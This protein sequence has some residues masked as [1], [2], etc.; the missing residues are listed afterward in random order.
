[1]QNLRPES[2]AWGRWLGLLAVVGMFVGGA[3]PFLPQQCL[4]LDEATQMTGLRLGPTGVA[5]WLAGGEPH[6]TGQFRDRM[7]PLSYWLGWVWAR[8]FGFDEASLRWFGVTCVAVAAALVYEA[9]RLALGTASAWVAGLLFAL[10]PAVIVLSVEIRAYPLFVLWSAVAFYGLV[11]LHATSPDERRATFAAL[12]LALSAAVST[13]FFGAVLGGSML[14]TLLI[15]AYR[16]AGRLRLIVGVGGVFAVTTASLLPFIIASFAYSKHGITPGVGYGPRLG[17]VKNM[18]VRL[19][20]HG[21]LS[22]HRP[23]A[24]VA[25]AAAVVLIVLAIGA[26]RSSR[27]PVVA[28]ALTLGI[29]LLVVTAAKL[30]LNT[31]D[32]A[33]SNYNVWMRPGFCILL[34][35]GIASQSRAVRRVAALAFGLLLVAQMSGAYQL[36]VHGNYFAHGPHRTIAELIHSLNTRD[37][38]VVHDDPSHRFEFVYCPI[39]Y[40]LGPGL[41]HY[42][43]VHAPDG[44]TLVRDYPARRGV[45][46]VTALP[47]RYLVVVRSELTN[48]TNLA[49]QVRGGEGA[50]GDGPLAR[51]LR[52]SGDWRSVS[53]RLAV[54]YIITAKIDLFECC[55][56]PRQDAP[57]V[58][59]LKP[60]A[61]ATTSKMRTY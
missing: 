46:P 2:S 41:E 44:S 59:H 14:A 53:E 36:A 29:G 56:P 48:P 47:Y 27:R 11:R 61:H 21:T 40:E 3:A 33:S 55:R 45:R 35:A 23:V 10:C 5:R 8:A 34:S 26:A 37:I 57:R 17:G 7:P 4:W 1:M 13:H 19:V 58:T 49:A 18:L 50:L 28:V 60:T 9:A 16:G 24:I 39:R 38:A 20:N 15:L 32:A 52:T 51:A 54:A 25:V 22:V 6:D 31:F 12:A 43:L 30:A 42:E